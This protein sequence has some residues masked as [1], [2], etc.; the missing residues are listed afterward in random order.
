MP[1]GRQGAPWGACKCQQGLVQGISSKGPGAQAGILGA[2]IAC[3]AC[4]LLCA[5]ACTQAHH[6]LISTAMT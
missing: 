1:G 4:S 2:Q 3:Q 6:T 5:S